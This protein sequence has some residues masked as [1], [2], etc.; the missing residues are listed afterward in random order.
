MKIIIR[1]KDNKDFF[2]NKWEKIKKRSKKKLDYK[3]MKSKVKKKLKD[4]K[5]IK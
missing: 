3:K 2:Y 5:G 4:K 1:S